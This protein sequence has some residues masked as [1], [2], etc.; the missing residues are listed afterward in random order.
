MMAITTSSS[1]NVKALL[2]V[3]PLPPKIAACGS[4]VQSSVG[5]D[6]KAVRTKS[7]IGFEETAANGARGFLPIRIVPN[8]ER[9]SQAAGPEVPLRRKEMTSE[10]KSIS[11]LPAFYAQA[12]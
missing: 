12:H 5:P 10:S 8:H 9:F 7:S 1:I 6:Y 4:V 11:L 2:K 3:A